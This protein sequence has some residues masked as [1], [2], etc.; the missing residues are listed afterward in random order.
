MTLRCRYCTPD[1]PV[2][3]HVHAH[4]CVYVSVA[5][6]AVLF[7]E[8]CESVYFVGGLLV[9]ACFVAHKGVG[10]EVSRSLL[11]ASLFEHLSL[12]K[13]YFPPIPKDLSH[14][15]KCA[16]SE[17]PTRALCSLHPWDNFMCVIAKGLGRLHWLAHAA[18]H[19]H[20][21]GAS[22][23]G[24]AFS[25]LRTV[26]LS[27]MDFSPPP[28]KKGDDFPSDAVVLGVSFNACF[29]PRRDRYVFLNQTPKKNS[30]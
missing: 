15:D 17:C 6:T 13:A 4:V 7:W 30:Q 12:G 28:P 9:Y 10:G 14:H 8:T 18:G 22:T 11:P 23:S 25:P 26:H 29:T 5:L 24:R 27:N 16:S 2:H 1:V 20:F 19:G 21:F 3:A